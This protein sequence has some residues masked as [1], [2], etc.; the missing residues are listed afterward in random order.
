MVTVREILRGAVTRFLPTAG[1]GA[2]ALLLA[3]DG[4]HV[5]AIRPAGWALLAG[6]LVAETVGFS[7][8]LVRARFRL[9]VR[10]GITGRRSV[11]AGALGIVGLLLG[12][13]FSQGAGIAW[14]GLLATGCGAIAGAATYWPWMRRRVS[15]QELELW[16]AV[17]VTALG[18]PS[19]PQRVQVAKETVRVPNRDHDA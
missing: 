4:R 3:F 11:I 19:P 6:M 12:S 18:A 15:A 14:A 9:E 13:I 1:L 2:L 17:D 7:A 8:L 16:E 5:A 10:A